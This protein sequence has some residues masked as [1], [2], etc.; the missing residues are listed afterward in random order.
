MYK[1]KSDINYH[2]N[3]DFYNRKERISKFRH[4]L[5]SLESTLNL[6]VKN[7][8]EV[9]DVELYIKFIKNHLNIIEEELEGITSWI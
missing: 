1:T 6:E 9:E 3:K 8:K 2:V 7:A 5:D 4:Q